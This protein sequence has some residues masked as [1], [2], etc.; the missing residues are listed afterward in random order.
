MRQSMAETPPAIS[1]TISDISMETSMTTMDTP[2]S[3]STSE[4]MPSK[5]PFLKTLSL[6]SNPLS[7]D[8]FLSSDNCTN[9][10]DNDSNVTGF[11]NASINIT[12]ID[13]RL[14]RINELHGNLSDSESDIGLSVVMKDDESISDDMKSVIST[15]DG[16]E[17]K[18]K[19]GTFGSC[20]N[21]EEVKLDANEI[22][23]ATS[24]KSFR[25]NSQEFSCMEHDS[26]GSN[27]E[28]LE[29]DA[30]DRKGSRKIIENNGIKLE[31]NDE[32]NNEKVIA[33]KD[34][35]NLKWDCGPGNVE[36][37]SPI[38]YQHSSAFRA[39]QP[40][41]EID[42]NQNEEKTESGSPSLDLLRKIEIALGKSVVDGI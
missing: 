42:D 1:A 7:N 38:I 23:T 9:V 15:I 27:F 25:G 28:Q 26:S 10:T 17:G 22:Y 30:G 5:A 3:G 24:L 21:D 8:T 6:C 19:G 11:L 33:G 36:T 39:L 32:V 35:E 34:T 4:E 18:R 2:R 29:I 20:E 13:D 12:N 16:D 40:P 14:S 37:E 41:A 31:E